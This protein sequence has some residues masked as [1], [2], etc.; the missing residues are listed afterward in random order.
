MIQKVAV[1][2]PSSGHL[3]GVGFILRVGTKRLRGDRDGIRM[4]K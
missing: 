4:D 1:T 2:L 3:L